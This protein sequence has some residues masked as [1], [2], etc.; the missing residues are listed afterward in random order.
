MKVSLVVITARQDPGFLALAQSVQ[1]SN[2]G[3]VELILVDRLKSSRGDAWTEACAQA[4][5]PFLHVEDQPITG[6]CPSSARNLGI[7]KAT[8]DIIICLDDLTTFDQNFVASHVARF[9]LGF[10]AIAGSYIE[11]FDGQRIADPRTTD[12]RQ[13]S[14]AWISNRFYG[15]HMAFTKAA[16][17]AVGGFD[18]AFDGA[19]GYE[20]CDFG[21]R[22]FRA[23]FSIGWFP[24]LTVLCQKDQRH[25]L[26]TLDVGINYQGIGLERTHDDE[27]QTIMYGM[28]KWKNDRLLALNDELKALDGGY[29]YEE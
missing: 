2:H 11:E 5:I 15:M 14:G 26:E 12:V 25:H 29:R 10:D 23:G 9:A 7:S 3:D 17:V 6:P 4:K 1:K 22:I 13:D 20:D 21:R 24:E 8:G 27:A 16:W 18:E 19:Y 28:R